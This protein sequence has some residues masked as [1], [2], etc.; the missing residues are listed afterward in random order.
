[1]SE[2]EVGSLRRRVSSIALLAGLVLFSGLLASC[3]STQA[4]SQ[5][6]G[7]PPLDGEAASTPPT[8]PGVGEDCVTQD[9]W[10][11]KLEIS[12]GIAGELKS[13]ALDNGGVFS[14]QDR[15]TGV[16]LAGKLGQQDSMKFAQLLA[17]TCPFEEP[18]RLPNCADCFL[19]DLEIDSGGRPNRF[20][21]NGISLQGS[22]FG[23]LVAA[24]EALANQAILDAGGTPAGQL[25]S[26]G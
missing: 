13:L 24:L 18:G 11:V 8:A 5:A 21:F 19:Y 14:V 16:D 1:M 6:P 3:R 20:H 22:R 15:L 4:A 10:Q 26:E 7:P 2:A 12:G 25:D 23:P 17:S 9:Q